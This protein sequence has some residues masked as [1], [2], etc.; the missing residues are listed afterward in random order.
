[1]IESS[2][3]STSSPAFGNV[4]TLGLVILIGMVVE[5]NC[6]NEKFS[7]DICFDYMDLMTTYKICDC[8]F[9]GNLIIS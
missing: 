1:M 8:I 6:F 4:S 9:I 5:F 7:N 2:C 3:C